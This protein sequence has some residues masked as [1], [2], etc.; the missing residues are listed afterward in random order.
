MQ[1]AQNLDLTGI[2]DVTFGIEQRRHISPGGQ[3]AQAFQAVVQ[4]RHCEVGV[5][6]KTFL[7]EGVQPFAKG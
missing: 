4:A 5:G 2:L 6:G 3:F 1:V 7:A